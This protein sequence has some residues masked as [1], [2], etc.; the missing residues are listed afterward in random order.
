MS[1]NE[2]VVEPG[3]N[4][5]TLLGACIGVGMRESCIIS[6]YNIVSNNIILGNANLWL[7]E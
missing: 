2:G 4:D 1:L 3:E 5:W 7:G 6:K